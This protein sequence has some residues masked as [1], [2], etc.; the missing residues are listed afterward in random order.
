VHELPV[1]LQREAG[2]EGGVEAL[3]FAEGDAGVAFGGG[4]GETVEEV[5]GAEGGLGGFGHADA[6]LEMH[7]FDGHG[8]KDAR[9]IRGADVA[10]VEDVHTEQLPADEDGKAVGVGV[11]AEGSYQFVEVL[12][13]MRVGVGERK[14]GRMH[15]VEGVDVR[16]FV[17]H[18]SL[19]GVVTAALPQARGNGGGFRGADAAGRDAAAPAK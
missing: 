11:S 5:D 7:G 16:D 2:G 6:S 1:V 15:G 8:A 4:A 9:E 19:V 10:A 14:R 13:E 18:A 3:L 12:F 17:P